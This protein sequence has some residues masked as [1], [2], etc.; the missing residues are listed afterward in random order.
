[1]KR[2]KW[3]FRLTIFVS[4]LV[5]SLPASAFSS[6][7]EH[8]S[9]DVLLHDGRIIKVE[10]EVDWTTHIVITDPFFGL[11][12]LPHISKSWPDKYW[13]KFKH[14][15]TQETIRW[16]GEQYFD[17]VLLDIVDGI[18]YLVVN[19]RT[20][21]STDKF[22]G[23]PELPYIFLKYEKGF[24]GKWIPIPVGQAPSVLQ[25]ANLSPDYPDFPDYSGYSTQDK[26]NEEARYKAAHGGRAS[27][28]LSLDQVIERILWMEN[29]SGGEFQA[30]IPRGYDDWF[31]TAKND[32]RY[33]RKQGDCRPP[34]KQPE[35]SPKFDASRQRVND[36]ILKAQTINATIGEFTTNPETIRPEDFSR[37]KGIWT[38]N[39]YM[40][41]KCNGIVKK[42][43]PI[44]EYFDNGGWHLLGTQL[45]LNTGET[46]PFQ[47]IN[48][49]KFQ[50]PNLPQLITCE[51][52]TIYAV[53]REN[54][55]DLY[56]YRISYSGEAIDA[57]R[58][59]LPDVNK[60][61]AGKEWGEIWEVT[62]MK[63][64]LT[65]ALA[66]YVYTATANL[67]GTINKK[68]IYA[69]D[70]PKI[71]ESDSKS[72]ITRSVTEKELDKTLSISKSFRDCP[73]CPEMVAIPGKKYAM[74]K[75]EITQSEYN[76]IMGGDNVGG[77]D[78]KSVGGDFFG[79]SKPAIYM[80][81]KA[82][83]TYLSRLNQVSGKEYRLPTSDEWEFACYGGA[84]TEY[85][86]SNDIDA[87]AWYAKNS[88]LFPH[89]VGQ[90]QANG[91][92]IYDMSGNVWE[93]VSDCWQN[94]CG[95]HMLRGG[96]NEQYMLSVHA[97]YI[98]AEEGGF[99]DVGLRVA[100]TLP[101]SNPTPCQNCNVDQVVDKLKELNGAS[102]TTVANV[103]PP[104]LPSS[105]NLRVPALD[106][107][108]TAPKLGQVFKD[109]A[110]CPDMVVVPAGSFDMGSNDKSV[111]EYVNESPAHRVIIAKAFAMGKTEVTQGQWK[112][113]MG[114][115][116]S[117]FKSC[118][119]TCPV[120]LV[121][122]TDAKEFI[123]KI[124][125]KTGKEYRLPSEAEWEYACRAGSEYKSCGSDNTD[126]VAWYENNSNKATHPAATKLANSW[127]LYDMSGN[128]WEW[129]E[130]CFH[131]NYIGAPTDGSAWTEGNS[132]VHV[133]RGGAWNSVSERPPHGGSWS[134]NTEGSLRVTTRNFIHSDDRGEHLGF[135]VARTLQ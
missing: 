48:I 122:W 44:R 2:I 25:D 53:G 114:S 86:G 113:V 35:P 72:N 29:R 19:G 77:V 51:N 14:P 69:V 12:T 107:A 36:A 102:P 84:Q 46:I 10:R 26:A 42:V 49:S 132:G 24:S 128:V 20:D 13:L 32:Y 118:G 103:E 127:G 94:N 133:I 125:A 66:D 54:K 98:R 89:P 73:S 61:F 110:D 124:N 135:R 38:G 71:R 76:A 39:N 85:C 78:R 83:Q 56:I 8:W 11:P 28:D 22:Y 88:S 106:L 67:G 45:V 23:C 62:P 111:S 101:Y 97:A 126:S 30:K 100:Q 123:Q 130:D 96:G 16:Q 15:D 21:K 120:E 64:H 112:A 121:S 80:N 18:P 58:V 41:S 52:N 99:P 5:A 65:I 37:S 109:C 63:N 75:Y 3:T 95:I 7:T 115:N 33:E 59:A 6:R 91:Y 105:K 93:W 47:Q 27:R 40:S 131:P 134:Y 17:P 1:M 82:V 116:P 92:G 74:G 108:A 70:L 34:A 79:A 9:E 81:W 60:I 43:E 117:H 119:D 50:A 87:V 55:E 57:L 104:A 129:V 90:Q 68:Q 4:F 31:Y